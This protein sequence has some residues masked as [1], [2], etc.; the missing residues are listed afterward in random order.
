MD[1]KNL[2]LQI[3]NRI[4]E[5]KDPA[6]LQTIAKVLDLQ[7]QTGFPPDDL[8]QRDLSNAAQDLQRSIDEVF[9]SEK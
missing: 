6:L 1:L 8:P 2:K 9:G 7:H 4:I 5:T 3:I